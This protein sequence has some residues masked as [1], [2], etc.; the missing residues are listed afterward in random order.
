MLLHPELQDTHTCVLQHQ[1]LDMH[2][3][4]NHQLHDSAH[5]TCDPLFHQE[6]CR[7]VVQEYASAQEAWGYKMP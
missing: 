1:P 4:L 7:G 3:L 5:V 6:L 2:T